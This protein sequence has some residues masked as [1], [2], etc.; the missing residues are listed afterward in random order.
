MNSK[1]NLNSPRCVIVWIRNRNRNQKN[2]PNPVRPSEPP[3]RP[4][5]LFFLRGPAPLHS[6]PSAPR[7]RS[8]DPALAPHD[9]RPSAQARFAPLPPSRPSLPPPPQRAPAHTRTPRV[10][11]GPAHAPEPA[12]AR[13]ARARALPPLR[14]TDNLGPPATCAC[15]PLCATDKPTPHGS[16]VFPAPSVARDVTPRPTTSTREVENL[17]DETEGLCSSS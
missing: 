3:L 11:F 13:I 7:S 17:S 16:P 4:V 10:V 9:P 5:L 14:P 15:A 12:T 6:R 2:N 1:F 8:A